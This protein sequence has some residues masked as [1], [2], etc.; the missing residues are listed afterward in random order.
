MEYLIS[1][2]IFHN[3]VPYLSAYWQNWCASAFPTTVTFSDMTPAQTQ[4]GRNPFCNK[5]TK[6]RSV[7]VMEVKALLSPI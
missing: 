2:G 4:R 5:A 7:S 1:P 6:A 3:E